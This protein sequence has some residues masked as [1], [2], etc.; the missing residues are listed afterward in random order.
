MKAVVCQERELAVHEVPEPRP[1]E[2]QLLLDVVRCG[3]CGSDLHTRHHADAVADLVTEVGYDDYMRTD[4]Q[5]V[6]GHEFVGTVA[7]QGKGRLARRIDVGTPVV[8]LPLVR[9]DGQ[10]Q[11]TGLSAKAPGGYAEQVLVE[12]AFAMPVPDGLDLDLAALTE[13]LAVAWH[14][15]NRGEVAKGD[16]AVVVGCGPVGLAVIAV[17]KARGVRTV[18]ASDPSAGRRALATALG[19]DTVVDPREESPFA[20]AGDH[21][22]YTELTGP[23][24]AGLAAMSGLRRL[25]T[26]WQHTWRLLDR[27]GATAPKRPVVFECVGN[28]GMIDQ[29]MSAAPLY[30]RVVVVGVCMG[31]DTIR[32]SMGINK[33]TDLRFVFGYTPLEFHDSLHALA[34]ERVDLAPLLTGRVGFDGVAGAFDVLAD[35]EQHAKI[36]VDPVLEGTEVKPAR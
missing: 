29:V 10:V 24:R 30:S 36:L 6:M 23:F 1:G 3:I 28:P 7:E 32:P 9:V 4:Q 20:S 2:G 31:D 25:P 16:V 13:P 5:V 8:A 19:A 11:A 22:H 14:A 21:G 18:I 34:G 35:P 12:A 33:E 27:V 17:L 26:P 15:V